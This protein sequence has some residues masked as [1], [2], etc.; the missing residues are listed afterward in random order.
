MNGTTVY[1]SY[2][3]FQ[4]MTLLIPAFV[5]MA[6]A[7]SASMMYIGLT[8]FAFGKWNP[9]LPLV[10]KSLSS[11]HAT[12]FCRICFTSIYIAFEKECFIYVR[13]ILS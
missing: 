12:S 2:W 6:F 11:E 1:I 13:S 10:F 7:H 8:L 3:L 4:G 9:S 5:F